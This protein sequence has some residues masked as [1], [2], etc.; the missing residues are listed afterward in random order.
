MPIYERVEFWMILASVTIFCQGEL[1]PSWPAIHTSK[2]L[3][4]LVPERS[5]DC[6]TH[7]PA[8]PHKRQP[9]KKFDW[10]AIWM[11]SLG[12]LVAHTEE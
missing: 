4:H 9:S 10:L 11:P 6:A 3:W 12:E 7:I 5:G 1:P 8:A 2:S